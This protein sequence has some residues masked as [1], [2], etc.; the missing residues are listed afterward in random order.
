MTKTFVIT[1]G[2][3][4]IGAAVARALFSRGDHAVVIG[5]DPRKGTRLLREAADSP[6]TAS[7]APADLSLA[8]ENRRMIRE[9]TEAHPRIDGLV[10]CARFFQTHRKVTPE[11]FEHNF[12]LFYLS[13]FL[14]S[15]GMVDALEKGDTPVIINVAGPGQDIP[16]NWADLQSENY[17]GVRA[18][19]TTGRYHDLLGVDFAGRH[20]T[21]PVRYV[22]FNPGPTSTSFAGEFD[23]PTGRF[24]EQQK[25]SAKPATEV[26]PPIVG[27]L[28][29]PPA[30]PLS[31]FGGHTRIGVQNDLFSPTAAARLAT[32]T[33]QLLKPRAT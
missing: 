2:T 18:M 23:A 3:D 28:D 27:I 12:A 26:V 7:F 13:R 9:L 32:I 16:I 11:G 24:V 14:L 17:D 20:G 1:G 21:G 22:L 33:E 5:T 30:E 6:G 19:F 4:G 31:A 25:A 29:A 8:S 10:L 15:H